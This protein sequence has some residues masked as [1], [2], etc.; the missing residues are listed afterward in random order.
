MLWRV[1]HQGRPLLS[2]SYF[3]AVDPSDTSTDGADETSSAHVNVWSLSDPAFKVRAPS[4]TLDTPHGG[5]MQILLFAG[6][7]VM[8]MMMMMMMTIGCA[9]GLFIM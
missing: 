8:V 1:Q 3:D 6:T 5:A 7:V 2:Y 9:S 4:T